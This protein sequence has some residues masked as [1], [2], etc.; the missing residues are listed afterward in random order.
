METQTID[1]LPTWDAKTLE[2]YDTSSLASGMPLTGS[3]NRQL[4]RFYLKREL[5]VYAKEA[6]ISKQGSASNIKYD[7]REVEKLMVHIITPGDKNEVNDVA[8]DWHKREFFKQYQAFKQGKTAPLGTPL[9]EAAFVGPHVATELIA[10]GCH[11]IEQLADGSDELVNNIADGWIL[12]DYARQWIKV[13]TDSKSLEQINALRE[14][15]ASAKSQ[16]D[17]SQAQL[18]DLRAEMAEMRGLLLDSKGNAVSS[19][20]SNKKETKQDA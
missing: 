18:E 1:G 2:G 3:K 14:Q 20:K 15:L 4:V 7:T 10:M 11:T 8:T 16:A 5:Q 19:K 6:T 17:Q 13:Q 9:A 12:R